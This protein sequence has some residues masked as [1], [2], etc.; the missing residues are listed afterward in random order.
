MKTMSVTAGLLAFSIISGH[1]AEPS[2]RLFKSGVYTI[3]VPESWQMVNPGKNQPGT[4]AVRM[5]T[6]DGKQI[7]IG[8]ILV[9]QSSDPVETEYETM[10][11]TIKETPD[12]AKII[13]S[14]DIVLANG[15]KG[16]QILNSMSAKDPVLG[17][18]LIFCSVYLPMP[19]SGCVIFK[20]RYTETQKEIVKK[21]FDEMMSKVKQDQPQQTENAQP[22]PQTESNPAPVKE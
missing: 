11:I 1:T 22:A 17:S 16:K 21:E 2:S 10:M 9:A 19:Q 3:S 8:E 7:K 5:D 12:S 20:L 14:G 15:I 4:V 13:S 18:P 6:K